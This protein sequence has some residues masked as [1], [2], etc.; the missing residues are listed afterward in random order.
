MQR[1]Y[2]HKMVDWLTW[3]GHYAPPMWFGMQNPAARGEDR[4]GALWKDGRTATP[5]YYL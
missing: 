1:A 5:V 2:F 4:I 3:G